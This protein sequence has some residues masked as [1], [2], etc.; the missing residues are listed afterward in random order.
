MPPL[1]NVPQFSPDSLFINRGEIGFLNPDAILS[2]KTAPYSPYGESKWDSTRVFNH[3]F[4][5]VIGNIMLPFLW[6]NAFSF[7]VDRAVDDYVSWVVFERL[8][9][10]ID[11]E[12]SAFVEV[13][14]FSDPAHPAHVYL[15][16]VN[17]RVDRDGQRHIT[18]KLKPGPQSTAYWQVTNVLT[19]TVWIVRALSNTLSINHTGGFTEYFSAGSG[20]LFRLEPI[21]FPGDGNPISGCHTNDLYITRGAECSIAGGS[22]TFAENRSLYIEGKLDATN[23]TF[24]PCSTS[25]RG[26]FVRDSGFF[27]TNPSS[28]TA[29]C[30]LSRAAVNVGSNSHV[31]LRR[32]NIRDH[33]IALYATAFANVKTN[34]VWTHHIDTVA[35]WLIGS[36]ASLENDSLQAFVS[37]TN[38]TRGIVAQVGGYTAMHGVRILTYDTSISVLSAVVDSKGSGS[39]LFGKN[40]LVGGQVAMSVRDWGEIDF[41]T[42]GTHNSISKPAPSGYHAVLISGMITA[43]SN[44][45]SGTTSPVIPPWVLYPLN[46]RLTS[47]YEWLMDDP[48]PFTGGFEDR[49]ATIRASDQTHILSL[50]QFETFRRR[51]KRGDTTGIW[52]YFV[53]FVIADTS[54]I[55]PESYMPWLIQI[56]KRRDALDLKEALAGL[57]FRRSSLSTKLFAANLYAAF[58]EYSDAIDILNSYNF[59]PNRSLLKN[60]LYQKA[61]YYPLSSRSGFEKALR[62]VDSLQNLFGNDFLVRHFVDTYPALYSGLTP[63]TFPRLRKEN[64]I[65]KIS[66]LIPSQIELHQN[67]PNPFSSVSGI[68]FRLPDETE[69]SIDLYD[70]FG[71]GIR[72]LAQG[73]YSKGTHTLLLNA[74]DYCAGTYIYR[75]TTTEGFITRK[76]QIVK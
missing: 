37:P 71:R 75:L 18:I 21:E 66:Y 15:Y 27:N 53:Q 39:D 40:K 65:A 51:I 30:I 36:T 17:K 8:N 52:R 67:Y 63:P 9:Y 20:A 28:S 50:A 43:D 41:S 29:T 35:Y 45:W 19:N 56:A 7:N 62:S 64:S 16:V 44:Y 1:P 76:L 57:F 22:V 6:E 12:D 10:R 59:N 69:L 14:R 47:T 11:P 61:M 38:P 54:N 72:N 4:V 32:L 2:R 70:I 60:S 73:S 25:W 5:K 48:V 23:V 33:P 31:D 34:F 24:G 58:G 74:S 55:I 3:N 13:G 42:L 68:T 49:F 46:A 26:V